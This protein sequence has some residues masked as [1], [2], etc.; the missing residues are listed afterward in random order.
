MTKNIF[1]KLATGDSKRGKS[2]WRRSS[3]LP[4][5][6]SKEYRLMCENCRGIKFMSQTMKL[7]ERIIECSLRDVVE[8]SKNPYGFIAE[9]STME[10]KLAFR[11]TERKVE[12]SIEGLVCRDY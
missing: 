5:Y 10:P 4:F 9:R 2:E 7:L 8:I 1:N 6:K 12:R 3:L 11:Q